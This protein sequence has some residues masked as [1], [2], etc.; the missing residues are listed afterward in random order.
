MS[1]VE[2][3]HYDIGYFLAKTPEDVQTD[4]A[5]VIRCDE[6][7]KMDHS[8]THVYS[9]SVRPVPP[10][11]QHNERYFIFLGGFLSLLLLGTLFYQAA[12]TDILGLIR[13]LGIGNANTNATLG[14]FGTGAGGLIAGD[15]VANAAQPVL[16]FVYFAYN[17]LL[18][19]ISTALEWEAYAG[20]RKGLRVSGKP[21]GEQRS[22][23]FLQLPYRIALPLM[24]TSRVLHR[25]VSQ[26]LFMTSY[27]TY[28]YDKKTD[29]WAGEEGVGTVECGYSL[30]AIILTMSAGILLMVILLIT[31]MMRFRTATLV[32]TS[33]SAAISAACH[34]AEGE[35]E[36]EACTSRVQW[37]VTSSGTD[38]V[39][40]CAFSARPVT[41]P[42]D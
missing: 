36:K 17:G 34:A 15:I 27:H 40:H 30:L 21:Q 6:P 14:S 38:G 29:S 1:C 18:T 23:Y 11:N 32:V 35:E 20:K 4:A 22:T 2:E 39:G 16:S 42:Q 8:H 41:M 26:S 7:D 13:R 33:C 12:G 10:I 28:T 9:Y 37:G 25:L 24:V 5:A 31:G 19:S 3:R